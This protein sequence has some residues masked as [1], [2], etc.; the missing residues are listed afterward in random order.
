MGVLNEILKN[1]RAAI[2]RRKKAMPLPALKNL[3]FFGRSCCSLRQ[4]LLAHQGRAVIAEFKRRSPSNLHI[5]PDAAVARIVAGYAQAGAVA[6]SVLTDEAHFGGSLDDLLT[7][8]QHLNIPL[9]RKDFIVDAYQLWEAKAYG[10]DVVL[11]IAAAL[12]VNEAESFTQL[13]HSLG[14]EVLLEIHNLEELNQYQHIPADVVGVNNRNLQT[15]Q[16]S[17]DTSVALARVFGN[18]VVRIA[19]SGIREP[20]TAQKL[21]GCGYSGFLIGE[22]FMMQPDP[23]QACED[24][25]K[26]LTK[27]YHEAE[28]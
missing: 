16:T 21:A 24:F 26:Q 15:L 9:L 8:R 13:A 28:N 1:T 7:A 20:D 10:A 2:E 5:H 22:Y 6:V 27:K 18:Q 17:I 12:S 14:M 3:P 19:E 4:T 25:I 23:A 11:L